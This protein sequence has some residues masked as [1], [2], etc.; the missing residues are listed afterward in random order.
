MSV[1]V[2]G[3]PIDP[4]W[5]EPQDADNPASGRAR[6]RLLAIGIPVLVLVVLVGTVF[7]FGGFKDRDDTIT[8]VKLGQ[9]FTNGGYEFSFSSAT[10]QQAPSYGGKY[11]RIQKVTV[12]GTIR[13]IGDTA[14]SPLDG[15]FLARGVQGTQTETD[16][17]AIVG[18]PEQT[19]SPEDVTPGLPPVP[20]TVT[21]QFPPTFSETELLFGARGLTYGTHSY[22]GGTTDEYWDVSGSNLF[23]LR[24]PMKRLAPAQ[25]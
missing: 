7:A 8:D 20:L 4:T 18:N 19:N 1:W 3:G 12:T 9:T 5:D 22:F 13:N 17:V 25:Y 23:R 16:Q 14:A 15:W 6:R 24:I 11:K 21:F 10:I 2:D